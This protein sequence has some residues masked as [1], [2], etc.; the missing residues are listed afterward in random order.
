LAVNDKS[1]IKLSSDPTVYWLQNN[2]IYGIVSSNVL[3]TMKSN[4]MPGWTGSV[5]TVINLSPYVYAQKFIATDGSSNGLLMKLPNDPTVYEVHFGNKEALS[6]DVFNQRGYSFSNVIDVPQAI[7]NMFQ[8]QSSLPDLTVRVDTAFNYTGGQGV[9]IPVTVTRTGGTLTSGN[10]VTVRLYWSAD[11]NLDSGDLFLWASNSSIPDFPVGYLNNNGSKTVNANIAIPSVPAGGSYFIIAVVDPDFAYAEAD[12]NNNTFGAF[13]TIQSQQQQA[14]GLAL[15]TD[16][17]LFGMGDSP[18]SNAGFN[19]DSLNTAVGNFNFKNTD[20]EIHGRGFDFNLS[21]SYNSIDTRVGPMGRGWSHSFNIFLVDLGST[22]YSSVTV[23]YS[24]GKL[25]TYD[26]QSGGPVY[27]SRVA[28]I[29]DIL[30]HNGDDT[31]VLQKTDQREYHFTN[32]GKLFYI[33][34]RNGNRLSL[35]YNSDLTLAQVFDTVGRGYNFYYQNQL[36]TDVF[37]SIGRH[38]QYFYSNGNLTACRDANGNFTNYVYDGSNRLWQVYDGRGTQIMT[39]T[40]DGQGRLQTQTNGR[41]FLWQFSYDD[42]N[43]VTYVTDPNQRTAVYTH[44]SRFN[45]QRSIDRLNHSAV[46][47]YDVGNNRSR[48][49]DFNNNYFSYAYDANGNMSLSQDPLNKSRQFFYDGRNNPTLAIDELSHA[50]SMTYDGQGNLTILR[51][52]KNNSQSVTY[53]GFGEA[54][55]TTDANS[56]TSFLAYDG[57]GNLIRFEDPLHNVTTFGYDGASRR[58]SMTD[59]RGRMTRYFYDNNDNVVAFQKPIGT[60]VYSYD[61]AD[62]R[63]S[64]QDPNGYITR[65]DYDA[66]NNQVKETDPTGSF[67]QNTYDGLDRRVATRDKRGF[68]TTFEYDN[69]SRLTATTNPLNSKTSYTYDNNGNRLTVTDANNQTTQSLYDELNRLRSIRD[70]LNN[71]LVKDYDAAGRLIRETDG[72]GSVTQF[73]Y[74]EVNNLTQINDSEGGV[75]KYIYDPN[76]NLAL[77]IDANQHASTFNYDRLNRLVSSVDPL[78]NAYSYTYDEA[79]N[80]ITQTDAKHQTT[81]FIYDDNNRLVSIVYPDSTVVQFDYDA[82]GNRTQIREPLGTTRYVYDSLNRVTSYTDVYGKTIGY[83]YDPNGNVQVL[84]YPDG[85]QVRYDYDA[86]N[87]MIAVTDWT[88][89][90]LNYEYNNIDLLTKII[91]PS[92]TD[93]GQT[94]YSYDLAGRLTSLINYHSHG[95]PNSYAFTLD[96]NGNRITANIQEPL[97]NRVATSTQGYNYDAANRIQNAGSIT[98]TSDPNGN[99]TS[100]TENGMTTNYTY[101]FNDRLT[102]DQS[103]T[104]TYN[105]QGV[106]V[107]K[108]HS[109]VVTRYVVDVNRELS[110]VLCETDG[111]G[112]ITSYYI[113]GQ[114]LIYKVLPTANNPHYYYQFDPSGSTVSMTSDGDFYLNRY[115]YDPFGKVTNSAEVFPNTGTTF[116]NQFKFGGRFGLIDEGNG[117]VYVRA[118][119]YAP[120]LGRFMSKDPLTGDAKDG[121]SLNRY[122]YALDNPIRLVDADGKSPWDFVKSLYGN[123]DKK[124]TI[125]HAIGL[126]GRKLER[127]GAN[128]GDLVYKINKDIDVGLDVKGLGSAASKGS[129]LVGKVLDVATV[130]S[131]AQE[132]SGG[133]SLKDV[134]N[135]W[136]HIGDNLKFAYHNPDEAARAITTASVVSWNS[137]VDIATLGLG[138]KAKLNSDH[139]FNAL[140]T[141]TDKAVSAAMRNQINNSQKLPQQRHIAPMPRGPAAAPIM[142]RGPKPAPITPRGPSKKR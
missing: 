44:D 65:F 9:Q 74:D 91:P 12:E 102:N 15:G 130:Y 38:L 124:D 60:I 126:A 85:K 59:A 45:L 8:S 138:Y 40:Y 135:A 107:S 118:R 58:T 87:R 63:T 84:I 57:Q 49:S 10:S 73:T 48:V 79:G 2:K 29:Y 69:E 41:G 106:R 137:A 110:Q 88:G 26:Q 36:L 140:K 108:S 72:R 19:D 128:H 103:N 119:Y 56:N 120:E 141:G 53:N 22:G 67:V 82:N 71:T 92:I 112:N 5:T 31:W 18:E 1:L 43:H 142:P 86:D 105:A 114:G 75:T 93:N 50:T 123:L 7:L 94:Q 89:R 131:N 33:M 83:V 109:G 81:R 27:R 121:Q 76:H 139:V 6:L 11:P 134:G 28:G 98:F 30:V 62:N 17:G 136:W 100:K 132:Q 115:A 117:L 32:I 90:T 95:G 99:V 77:Q 37:D 34:D 24:D 20:F 61:Q 23:H 25:V 3:N 66:N 46:I 16:D 80:R 39:N 104:Y 70:P 116:P 13:V 127:W 35:S 42:V 97:P 125:N 52:A 96:Q 111:N 51:D 122:I 78:N 133:F 14:Q 68:T 4:N 55:T 21:R 129:K 101:D 47:E 54:V 64:V 113:Y